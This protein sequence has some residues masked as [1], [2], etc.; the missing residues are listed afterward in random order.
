MTNEIKNTAEL[1]KQV[2]TESESARNSD[3]KLYVELCMRLNP[4]AATM[5]FWT[6]L[7]NLKEYDLPNIET[8]RRTRQKLQAEFP[9][10]AGSEKI[11]SIRADREKDFREYAREG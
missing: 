8:V 5:P 1:V 11:Q 2:L 4:I 6:V 7:L 9:E 3:M 10:L